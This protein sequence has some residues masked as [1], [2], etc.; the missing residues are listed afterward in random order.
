MTTTD[1]T[2]RLREAIFGKLTPQQRA[3]ALLDAELVRILHDPRTTIET[4][5][6]IH[7]VLDCVLEI[8]TT[9]THG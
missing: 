1:G 4:A 2:E 6:R 9:G 7:D 3:F 8:L 5:D